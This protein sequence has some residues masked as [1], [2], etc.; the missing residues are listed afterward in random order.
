MTTPKAE[1]TLNEF[2]NGS[3]K[4]RE[5]RDGPERS[6]AHRTHGRV[7]AGFRGSPRGTCD[8]SRHRPCTEREEDAHLLL[9]TLGISRRIAEGWCWTRRTEGWQQSFS[10]YPLHCEPYDSMTDSKNE[11]DLEILPDQRLEFDRTDF[12]RNGLQGP[13]RSPRGGQE[14]GWV[15]SENAL[16]SR[17]TAE[18]PFLPAFIWKP[19]DTAT[20]RVGQAAL[21]GDP[22]ASGHTAGAWQEGQN[23]AAS[24]PSSATFLP[25]FRP[26]HCCLQVFLSDPPP[27]T[28]HIVPD[29]NT[30]HLD[31]Q[32]YVDFIYY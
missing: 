14:P 10:L 16:R 26:L 15:N 2:M 7:R 31:D 1:I 3:H 22:F 8:R 28:P 9:H 5:M 27:S 11:Y 30:L 32:I 23:K 12:K 4:H 25:A 29:F 6:E 18:G 13:K 21:L 20:P 19:T 17:Q 24:V